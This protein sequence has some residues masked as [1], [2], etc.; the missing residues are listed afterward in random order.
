MMRKET[1]DYICKLLDARRNGEELTDAELNF[2]VDQ[3]SELLPKENE[4]AE[5][6]ETKLDTE[7]QGGYC[8]YRCDDSLFDKVSDVFI[9]CS[10]GCDTNCGFCK[11]DEHGNFLFKMKARWDHSWN[12]KAYAAM[13]ILPPKED[14][15][16]KD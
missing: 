15:N 4:E 5:T 8:N 11:F 2:V 1:K 9:G 10:S 7:E 12:E 14:L 13:G 16:E 6:H 3:L